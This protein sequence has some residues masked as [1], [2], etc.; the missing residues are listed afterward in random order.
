MESFHHQLNFVD[1]A[2]SR[3]RKQ[4]GFLLM[5]PTGTGKTLTAA[6][7]LCNFPGKPWVVIA[8][9]QDVLHVFQ[10]TFDMI[11]PKTPRRVQERYASTVFL[12][13]EDLILRHQWERLPAK[14][15]VVCDEIHV[16]LNYFT[17]THVKH[18]AR[19]KQFLQEQ[20]SKVLM[21]SATP[22]RESLL[23]FVLLVGIL[24]GRDFITTDAEKKEY[25]PK[26]GYY[27]RQVLGRVVPYIT[28]PTSFISSMGASL[29]AIGGMHLIW[30]KDYRAAGKS[31]SLM[32]ICIVLMIAV[33]PFV[34]MH[35][36]YV[37]S[38]RNLDFKRLMLD[39]APYID[40]QDT[41]YAFPTMSTVKATY[42]LDVETMVLLT[43]AV[44]GT[45]SSQVYVDIGLVNTTTESQ[46]YKI[47]STAEY[48]R[49]G[50]LLSS[51]VTQSE[52]S[53]FM[54]VWRIM[55]KTK[56]KRVVIYSTSEDVLRRI[57]TFILKKLP[58][59]R[60]Y[61]TMP[62]TPI[63]P[64]VLDQFDVVMLHPIM[65]TGITVR[66]CQ[67]MIVLEVPPTMQ[68]TIQLMGRVRRL[69]SHSMFHDKKHKHVTYYF[70]VGQVPKVSKLK[71]M[72]KDDSLSTI[73]GKAMYAILPTEKALAFREWLQHHSGDF[74]YASFQALV[75]NS[76]TPE[77]AGYEA[78]VANIMTFHEMIETYQQL[79]EQ[80]SQELV[81]PDPE[82]NPWF[83]LPYNKNPNLPDCTSVE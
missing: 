50:S 3:M 26:V 14:C 4:R 31:F 66:G 8:P 17:S 72:L 61:T 57:H 65:I 67:S 2:S 79:V 38:M 51:Y 71:E 54:E 39:M 63:S 20:A 73:L 11:I 32:G 42:V 43:K 27:W 76:R 44:Y 40:Y 35:S 69:N 7:T 15:I 41:N 37:T 59:C 64:D 56:Y 33:A 82:C 19:F 13:Y 77:E 46:V 55:Q 30:W 9:T 6:A 70:L 16:I 62:G 21:L 18:V 29:G 45:L 60:I 80:P 58:S 10:E 36:R 83:P 24:R 48:I 78:C 22:F 12:T 75:D 52:P 81:L 47:T 68:E 53:K 28:T 49:V 74:T 1:K 34:M 25:R 5:H 23:D